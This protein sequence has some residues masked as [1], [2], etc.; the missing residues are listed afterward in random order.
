MKR[1]K[2]WTAEEEERLIALREK[3][4]SYEQ[5]TKYL[6]GRTLET[7]RK[8]YP[9]LTRDPSAPE[10]DRRDLWT[11]E[12]GELL[13]DLRNA[14]TSWDEV[15]KFFPKRNLQALKKMYYSLTRHPSAQ[16][17]VRRDAWT[18]E[19]AERLLSLREKGMSWSKM[20]EL[21]P[22]RTPTALQ[23]QYSRLKSDPSALKIGSRVPWR[24]DEEQRLLE[25]RK[26]GLS[27]EKIMEHI[28]GRTWTALRMKHYN[29]TRNNIDSL[30]GEST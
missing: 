12:E 1:G 15:A 2:A 14:G 21:F 20:T 6:P 9:R 7:V 19:E 26:Q 3:G 23:A 28:P 8:R 29:L 25:L 30:E 27:W 16:E 13:V 18:T 17:G 24:V 5:I 22:G 4:L 11:T 10:G